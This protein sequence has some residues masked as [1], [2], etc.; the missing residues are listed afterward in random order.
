MKKISPDTLPHPKK[1]ARHSALVRLDGVEHWPQTL[2]RLIWMLMRAGIDP[3]QI[4][5]KTAQIVKA[6]RNIRTLRIPPP[7]VLEYARVLTYWR[8]EPQFLDEQGAPRSLPITGGAS[9]FS[10]LLR[11][12]LPGSSVNDVLAVLRRHQLISVGTHRCVRLRASAFLP[13]NAQRAH[14]LAYTLSAVEGI[15]DTCHQNLNARKP[16][17]NIG[18]LQRVASAER[19]DLRFIKDY[20]LFL[21]HQAT[22]FL[23]KQDAWLK[24]HE[25]KSTGRGNARGAQVGVGVF[26]VRARSG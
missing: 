15:I 8:N 6:H 24:R 1:K 19:F 18:R 10:T 22:D 23:L 12:A 16:A 25:V 2:D 21:R 4:T 14:F 26:G 7:N 20:D 5:A 9:S 13:R 11:K 3:R 17:D